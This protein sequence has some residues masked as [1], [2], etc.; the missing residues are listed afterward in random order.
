[1]VIILLCT[2]ELLST[3]PPTGISS[4]L[5]TTL[6]QPTTTTN[7]QTVQPTTRPGPG[8]ETTPLPTDFVDITGGGGTTLNLGL[9]V[10][11]SVAVVLAGAIILTL[12]SDTCVHQVEEKG[13][14]D[15]W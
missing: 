10:G 3:S 4:C 7:V 2:L 9:N 14:S 13:S 11:V 5:S 8:D 1:M 6:P 12:V 15:S